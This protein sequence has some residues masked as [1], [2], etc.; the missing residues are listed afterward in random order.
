MIAFLG[1]GM[2][3]GVVFIFYTGFF[4]KDLPVGFV[5]GCLAAGV[6]VGVANYML[7]KVMLISK[8]VEISRIANAISNKDLTMS[9]SVKSNDVIGTIID[10]FNGMAANLRV[11]ISE[12]RSSSATMSDSVGSLTSAVEETEERV[13]R[14]HSETGQVSNAMDQMT[15]AVQDVA[16]NAEKAAKAAIESKQEAD[17]GG[18]VVGSTVQSINALASEVEQAAAVIKVLE[19]E[20]ENIGSVLDVIRGIAEQTNLLALNAAIEAARAGEQ[21][22]GFAVV[23]D[24]VRTLAQRTQQSTQEIQSMIEKLQSGSQDAVKVMERGRGQASASVEQAAKAGLSLSEITSAVSAISQM[25]TQIAQAADQQ[26][27]MAS[28]INQN[29]VNMSEIANSSSQSSQKSA[30]ASNELMGLAGQLQDI[31]ADYKTA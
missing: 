7:V 2:A 21:G 11:L 24:E 18:Q 8:L 6:I 13:Q 15:E 10:S 14:Q 9:C 19:Q 17:T 29:I 5:V 28:D 23:A 31:V 26:R 27:A 25:N 20:S 1:F 3:M 16:R 30:T 22:R 12:L 4:F